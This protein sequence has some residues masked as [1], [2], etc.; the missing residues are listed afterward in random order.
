[1]LKEIDVEIAFRQKDID[2]IELAQEEAHSKKE[3]KRQ[4]LGTIARNK[5]FAD[6]FQAAFHRSAVQD[7][8]LEGCEREVSEVQRRKQQ[9][10]QEADRL[11]A[12]LLLQSKWQDEYCREVDASMTRLEDAIAERDATIEALQR[13]LTTLKEGCTVQAE[14]LVKLQSKAVGAKP[15]AKA[16]KPGVKPA[17]R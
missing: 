11:H 7:E 2:S 3:A 9:L 14:E 15:T 8:S 6:T 1:M 17:K 16:S 12:E 4:R 5:Q 13:E 10:Q